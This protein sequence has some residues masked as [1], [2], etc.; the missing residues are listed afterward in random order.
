M[1]KSDVIKRTMVVLASAVLMSGCMGGPT[2]EEQ[3]MQDEYRA[4]MIKMMQQQMSQ[5]L[6]QP[7]QQVTP[8]AVKSPMTIITEDEL[9]SKTVSFDATTSGVKFTKFQDGFSINDAARFMDYEGQI[10]NYGYDWK[11]GDVTYMIEV[12]PKE[13]K[14]KYTRALSS[15]SPID[16]ATVTQNGR[17]LNI[18]TVTGKKLNSKGII[19]T[20]RGF[21]T[22]RNATAFQYTLGKVLHRLQHQKVGI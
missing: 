22:L 2:P 14:I 13:Y 9:L 1:R 6:S 21:I 7:E 20:S 4:Q 16:I 3:K 12:A 10:I 8:V 19:L 15:Q 5:G 17:M 18:R 11:S